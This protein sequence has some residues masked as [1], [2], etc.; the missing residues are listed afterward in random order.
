M[1]TNIEAGNGRTDI[2]IEKD[3]GT[4][5][6]ILELKAVQKMDEL[7]AACQKAMEQIEAKD[8]AFIFRDAGIETIWTYGIAFCRKT[9]RVLA[10]RV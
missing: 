1:H 6:I 10:K 2:A 5:G 4:L 8:Y 7:D 9:C 3:D